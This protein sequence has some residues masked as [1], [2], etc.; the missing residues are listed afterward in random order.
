MKKN[1]KSLISKAK[2]GNLKAIRDLAKKYYFG[3][4]KH[5]SS[6]KDPK[7]SVRWLKIGI[8]KGDKYC[9]YLLGYCYHMGDGVEQNNIKAKEY[10]EL[11]AKKGS[12]MALYNLGI[13]YKHGWA[14][15]KNV[16]KALSYF[17]KIL[18]KKELDK[19]DKNTA[20]KGITGIYFDGDG[21]KKN[22][23][24]GIKYCELAAKGGD[25]RATMELAY[26]Y[27]E[28]YPMEKYKGIKKNPVLAHKY[29]LLLARKKFIH[30]EIKVAEFYLNK[31]KK[32]IDIKKNR[33]LFYKYMNRA[34]E[35]NNY[36]ILD[37][38]DFK[39]DDVIALKKTFK[40]RYEKILRERR[41]L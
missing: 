14:V 8:S 31:M 26:I 19:E 2:K 33:N 5:A 23:K 27:D 12:S 40:K 35:N 15:R 6:P 28:E 1:I 9:L 10:W 24:K 21:I 18:K 13:F 29:Y 3:D 11:A 41:S 37:Q 17:K 20:L 30:A 7:K 22:L 25:P 36:D 16:K 32:G 4:N 38:F 34:K 39:R